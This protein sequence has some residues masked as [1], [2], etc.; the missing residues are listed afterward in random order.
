MY[1]IKKQNTSSIVD[2]FVGNLVAIWFSNKT[3]KPWQFKWPNLY[4][5]PQLPI[6]QM[7]NPIDLQRFNQRSHIKAIKT[8]RKVLC[9]SNC[10]LMILLVDHKTLFSIKHVTLTC[11][12]SNA[13]QMHEQTTAKNRLNKHRV[14]QL[15]WLL[16]AIRMFKAFLLWYH[17]VFPKSLQKK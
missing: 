8:I 14:A 4:M 3:F 1:L 6:Q 17:E 12:L 2:K 11:Y 5:V 9:A 13:Q 7:I 16:A 10:H 15:P